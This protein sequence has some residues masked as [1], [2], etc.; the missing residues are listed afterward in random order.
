MTKPTGNKIGRPSKSD[1]VE[2]KSRTLGKR[3]RPPGDAAII[4]DYKLRMLNS[5]KSA[6]VL[7]KIYE[8]ALN[9]EH[10]HQAAAWKLIMDRVVP[11][12]AFD[13][14]KQG[15]GVPQISINITGL[16]Q[17]KLETADDVIDIDTQ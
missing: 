6:K 2:T 13:I 8:A 11:V 3:G 10:A 14:S 16:N 15:G 7:E 17:P 1:L 12:S 9:D 5:P 4:N